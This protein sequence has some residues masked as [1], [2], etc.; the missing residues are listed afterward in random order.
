MGPAHGRLDCVFGAQGRFD[1]EGYRR[2]FADLS[3]AGVDA[4]FI[5][6]TPVHFA[7]LRLVVELVKQTGLPAMYAYREFVQAGG[8]MAYGVDFREIY[9]QMA[10]RVDLILRGTNPGEIPYYQPTKF[11]FS[12]NLKTA[13]QLGLTPPQSLLVQADEMI[14]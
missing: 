10:I 5:N 1:E 6:S 2:Q 11:V 7:N 9:G 13:N 14:E 4:L 3:S 8:F 12:V